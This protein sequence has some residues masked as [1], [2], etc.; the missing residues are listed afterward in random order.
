MCFTA[1]YTVETDRMI[2]LYSG[3]IPQCFLLDI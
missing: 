3:F 1:F 2:N